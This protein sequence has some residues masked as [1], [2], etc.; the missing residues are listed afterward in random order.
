[1]ATDRP[2][3]SLPPYI[4][5][6]RGSWQGQCRGAS[7]RAIRLRVPSVLGLVGV[8][9]RLRSSSSRT[10]QS[11]LAAGGSDPEAYEAIARNHWMRV[12]GPPL[13]ESDPP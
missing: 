7:G 10:Q 2:I 12:T 11:E 9:G 8:A 1:M 4:L 3:Q 13:A 6:N 5:D